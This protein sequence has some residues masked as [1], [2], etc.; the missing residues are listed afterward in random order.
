MHLACVWGQRYAG[1][2]AYPTGFASRT[3]YAPIA[4]GQRHCAAVARSIEPRRLTFDLWLF[5]EDHRLCDAIVGLV[6]VPLAADPPPP[7]WIVA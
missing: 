5:D 7:A 4:H 1:L 6:M 2:V 3:L